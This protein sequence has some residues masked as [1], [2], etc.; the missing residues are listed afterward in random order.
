[1]REGAFRGRPPR[2]RALR[3]TSGEVCRSVGRAPSRQRWARLLPFAAR[4]RPENEARMK[5]GIKEELVLSWV[6]NGRRPAVREDDGPVRWVERLA[7]LAS[8]CLF[9]CGGGAGADN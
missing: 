4:P 7:L 1:M 2:L 3:P 9:A 8:L 6:G 5:L